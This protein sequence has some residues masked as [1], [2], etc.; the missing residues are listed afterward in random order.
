MAKRRGKAQDP[1]PS[2]EVPPKQRQAPT[3]EGAD[4]PPAAKDDRLAGAERRLQE[5]ALAYGQALE[6][7]AHTPATVPTKWAAACELVDGAAQRLLVAAEIYARVY[8]E[9]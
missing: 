8:G 3:P 7:K 5:A 1:V 6:Q 2:P 9:P 4:E